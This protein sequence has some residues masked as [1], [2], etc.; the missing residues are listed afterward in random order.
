MPG[1]V[2]KW[3]GGAL[4]LGAA[5]GMGVYFLR[6]GLAKA[7]QAASVVGA[8]VGVAGL[9]L[10]VYGTLTARRADAAPS[11]PATRTA[12]LDNR[13]GPSD[14]AAVHNEVSGGVF[15]APVVQGRDFHQTD[16]AKP[17]DAPDTTAAG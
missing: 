5:I 2:V 12:P 17:A 16:L 6:I 10:A 11:P 9:A 7:D 15:H 8:F 3:V 14:S 4:F 1:R 13:V